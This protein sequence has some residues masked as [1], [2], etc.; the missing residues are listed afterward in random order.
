MEYGI[1]SARKINNWLEKDFTSWFGIMI[2][3]LLCIGFVAAEFA[4]IHEIKAAGMV[5]LALALVVNFFLILTSDNRT[6]SVIGIAFGL[7]VVGGISQLWDI[8]NT[9]G[10]VGIGMV[11][12]LWIMFAEL[13]YW[14]NPEKPSASDLKKGLYELTVE[15]KLVAFLSGGW[16][17]LLV[18]GAPKVVRW[19]ID[20]INQP[21]T[22]HIFTIIGGIAFAAFCIGAYL[23]FNS[24]KY[25]GLKEEA[26]AAEK[27]KRRGRK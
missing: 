25:R 11:F 10:L 23:W 16:I 3:T 2:I 18:T 24:F 20:A 6:K 5:A 4:A 12:G 22:Q 19:T 8:G 17:M 15:Y 14:A 9:N 26:E 1:E 7:L 27:K 13:V 21:S